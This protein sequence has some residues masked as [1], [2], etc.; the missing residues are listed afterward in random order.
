MFHILCTELDLRIQIY[1]QW[2]SLDAYSGYMLKPH[3]DELSHSE[4]LPSFN[5]CESVLDN[6]SLFA[7]CDTDMIYTCLT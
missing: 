4:C 6:I 5:Y 2:T 1:F 7:G 3:N